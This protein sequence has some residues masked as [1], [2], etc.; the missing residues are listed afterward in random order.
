MK[1]YCISDLHLDST[2][3]KP[4]NVFGA[5]WD[6]YLECIKNSW[7]EN[8]CKDDIVLISGDISWAMT[9]EQF[10][11][12]LKFF[13]NLPG[14]IIINRGNHDYWWSSI[15][16]VRNALPK[17]MYAL[18]NDCIEFENVIICGTRGWELPERNQETSEENLKIIN[19]EIIRMEITLVEMSRKRKH[20][21]KVIYMLHY[22]PFNTTR[23]Q[24]SFLDLLEKYNVDIV[25]YGHLHGTNVR[26]VL[27]ET[28][29]NITFYLTSCD[30]VQNQLVHID[31]N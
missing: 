30:Q 26:S 6:N 11:K 13:E 14:T 18:Q 16:Q 4:M 3:Q 31:L 20:N 22:P 15:S 29:N 27:K 19:R 9:M 24:N 5:Q 28:R 25:V 1:I 21:Q 2:G 12:D 17:N 23:Q 8:V 10:I 7:L